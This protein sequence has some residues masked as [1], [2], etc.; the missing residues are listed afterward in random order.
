MTQLTSFFIIVMLVLHIVVL[1]ERLA[2]VNWQIVVQPD[3][4]LDQEVAD[5]LRQR[6]TIVRTVKY[7]REKTGLGLLEAKQ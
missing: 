1:R 7:V 3:E 5:M 4:A 2:R 6:Q